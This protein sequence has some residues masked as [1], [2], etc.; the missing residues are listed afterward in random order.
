MTHLRALIVTGLAAGLLISWVNHSPAADA[1]PGKTAV[2]T[3]PATQPAQLGLPRDV[4]QLAALQREILGAWRGGACIGD[5]T[6]NADGTF[7]LDNFTPGQNHLTGTWRLMWDAIPPTLVLT[8]QTS[9]FR[10]RN[11]QRAEFHNLGKTVGVK[12]LKLNRDELS[13]QIPGDQRATD[14]DRRERE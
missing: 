8:Y 3:S 5:Y 1:K 10:V 14:Y 11:P 4:E 13:L 9:D 6:F 7:K 12:I 2:A